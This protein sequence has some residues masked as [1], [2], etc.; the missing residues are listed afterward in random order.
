QRAAWTEQ[1]P[2]ATEALERRGAPGAAGPTAVA[3]GPQTEGPALVE[4]VGRRLLVPHRVLV[5]LCGPVADR[6]FGDLRPEQPAAEL[7]VE[8]PARSPHAVAEQQQA[9]PREVATARLQTAVP[10]APLAIE[11]ER[12]LL[13]DHG[14]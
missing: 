9:E 3:D 14:E 7:R 4:P 10:A 2:L 8:H 11:V 5:G 6:F 12:V 1:H 13:A